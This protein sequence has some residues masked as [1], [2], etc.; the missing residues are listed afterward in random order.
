MNLNQ[1]SQAGNLLS[2]I[3]SFQ[4]FTPRQ[5]ITTVNG[6]QEARDFKL[7]K[8][9]RV[10]MIDAN[11]DILYIKECDEIGKYTLKVYECKE[12]TDK[13]ERENTPAVISR[14]EMD[15]MVK[16]IADIKAMLA[17]GNNGKH[18]VKKSEQSEQQKLNF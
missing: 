10:A 15:D 14:A 13:F 18:D 8:G 16:A 4:T 11:S 1:L 17:G 12:I 5:D 2:T 9:E 6:L 3:G 7:N